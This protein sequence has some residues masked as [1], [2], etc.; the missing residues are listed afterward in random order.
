[1]LEKMYGAKALVL[2][3]DVE[4]G[5]GWWKTV[6]GGIAGKDSLAFHFSE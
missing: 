6:L 2:A 1:M 3:G 5:L 4:P